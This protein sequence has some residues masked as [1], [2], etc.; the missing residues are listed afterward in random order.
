MAA[1]RSYRVPTHDPFKRASGLVQESPSLQEVPLGRR[2]LRAIKQLH[3]QGSELAGQSVF[4]E[5]P[6]PT[7]SLARYNPLR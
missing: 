2:W 1:E 5:Q 4:T 6:G 3:L 7:E